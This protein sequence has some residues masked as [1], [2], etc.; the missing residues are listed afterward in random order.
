MLHLQ[1]NGASWIICEAM[2]Y[3]VARKQAGAES[4]DVTV[5]HHLVANTMA[6]SASNDAAEEAGVGFSLF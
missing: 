5:P 3:L 2:Y 1:W 4:T 6:G